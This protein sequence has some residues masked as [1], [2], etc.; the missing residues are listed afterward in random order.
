MLKN[1]L[2]EITENIINIP[3]YS[4]SREAAESL[5]EID[6]SEITNLLFCAEKIRKR[7]KKNKIFLCSIINAKSGKC[8]QDCAFCAQSSFHQTQIETYPLLSPD[9]IIKDALSMHASGAT[10]YS[11]VTS[12]HSLTDE[13]IDQICKAVRKI[14]EKTNLTVCGS[15]GMLSEKSAKKLI[16]SGMTRY[17]HNLETAESHFDKICTTHKYSEDIDTINLATKHGFNVCSGGIFGLGESWAQRVELAFTLKNL[18][19]DTIPI[20]FLNPVAGTRME[21]MELLSPLDAIKIIALVRII[22]PEKNITIC[23]GREI[24]LKD[25][26]S[27]IFPAGTNGLMIGNYLTTSGRDLKMDIDMIKAYGLTTGK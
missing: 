13:E 6:N 26:Q 22:N 18:N 8:S 14:K 23:G 25:F 15:L 4:I 16:E 2:F 3:G 5:A 7:F 27:W 20:N 21:D 11:V 10:H 1:K 19:I 17:H 12:G 9:A 24:T